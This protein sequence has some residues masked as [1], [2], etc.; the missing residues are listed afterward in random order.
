[1]GSKIVNYLIVIVLVLSII[2]I[3]WFLVKKRLIKNSETAILMIRIKAFKRLSKKLTETY[4]VRKSKFLAGAILNKL[5]LD[6]PT[7]EKQ[8]EFVKNN[9]D[10]I[11]KEIQN[12]KKD[13]ELC[14]AILQSLAIQTVLPH[15]I[16][17]KKGKLSMTDINEGGKAMMKLKE[18]G[19]I[20]DIPE[21]PVNPASFINMAK[22]FNNE[23]E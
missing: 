12:L 13:T 11:L 10:T 5:F 17:G 14:E 22:Q 7:D 23:Q 6:E 20:D 19:L 18:Y 4:E 2:A 1:M 3:A 9:Q 21:K 16:K 15:V 8:I